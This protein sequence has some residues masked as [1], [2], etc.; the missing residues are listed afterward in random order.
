MPGGVQLKLNVNKLQVYNK[1]LIPILALI[2][3]SRNSVLDSLDMYLPHSE[4][5]D[6]E[7]T[8]QW[9]QIITLG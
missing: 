4:N 9:N 6:Y 7:L 5:P 2:S 3:L 8:V 1:P